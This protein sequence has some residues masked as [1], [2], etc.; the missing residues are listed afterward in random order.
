MFGIKNF[1]LRV[2]KYGRGMTFA[3]IV[4]GGGVTT[5]FA[6]F[7]Y[8]SIWAMPFML[9]FGILAIH[10]RKE[11]EEE[12]NKCYHLE[13]FKECILSVEASLRAGYAVENAFVE[14]IRDMKMMFGEHSMIVKE[15]CFIQTGLRNNETLES[16]LFAMAKESKISEILEF[17]EVFS[18]AKRNSGN[19][20][21]VIDLYSVVISQKI[22]TRQEIQ[23]VLAAKR[24]EQKV[25]NVMPFAM[26]I[27]LDTTNPGYF[28]MFFHNFTGVVLMSACLGIYVAAYIWSEKIFTKAY[29]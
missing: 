3:N 10:I 27:Y 15:L 23:T 25:M 6:Y 2:C 19:V 1:V 4:L 22:E 9:P 11:K 28:E 26:V 13:Q 20:S 14:S 18:I 29:E 21:G 7:F 5:F 16:L 12:R 17:A 24:L 8:R